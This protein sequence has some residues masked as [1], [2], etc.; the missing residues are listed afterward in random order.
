MIS[1]D[2]IGAKR[3]LADVLVGVGLLWTCTGTRV[4]V[5]ENLERPDQVSALRQCGLA[6][7]A[8]RPG[9]H[10]RIGGL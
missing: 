7:P 10:N 9:E 5:D 6:K 8:G 3:E 1:E 2:G 4:V